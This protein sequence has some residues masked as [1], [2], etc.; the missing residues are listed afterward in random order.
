MTLTFV[1]TKER[2]DLLDTTAT[3]RWEEFYE[4]GDVTREEMLAREIEAADVSGLLPTVIVML[5]DDVPIAMSAI[6]LDDLEGRP[7]LN[8]WLAGVYVDKPYRGQGYGT[9]VIAEL[10][11]LARREGVRR[12]TLYTPNAEGFYKKSGW[13]TIE[14][15]EKSGK[16]YSIMQKHL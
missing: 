12:L 3:W 2:R 5:E 8:P 4:G 11:S 10:E 14:T 7:E 15:L 9:R 13:T 16:T 6:C 1:T